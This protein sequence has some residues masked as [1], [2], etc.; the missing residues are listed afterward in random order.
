MMIDDSPLDLEVLQICLEDVGFHRFVVT[1]DSL[2]T[3]GLVRT[4][5]PDV[6]LLDLSMP[7][8]TGFELL[9]AFRS[10]VNLRDI[11]VMIVTSN[12]DAETKLQ[13]LELGAT[14]LLAKPVDPIELG[15]RLKNMLRAKAYRDSL[16]NYSSEL[17]K[18]V[19]QRT[20]QLEDVQRQ[21]IHCLARAAEYRDDDTGQ[22]VFRV[23]RYAAILA[24]EL[25]MDAANVELLEMAAQLHDVGKIGIPDAILLKPGKFEP[26]EF[27]V[28]RQHCDLGVSIIQGDSSYA[29]NNSSERVQLNT[30]PVV[31]MA[32]SIA[33]THHERWDGSGYPRGLKGEMIP[34][35][36]RIV[37]VADVFDALS[38]KRPYKDPMPLDKCV[39]IIR[40]GSGAHFD[41]RVVEAFFA[42]L[43]K[44]LAVRPV[45]EA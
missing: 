6:V 36:G 3:I 7:G 34:L 5:Q 12:T 9:T 17:E 19:R 10:D 13:S 1:S 24:S 43:D 25:G 20:R 30:I 45:A 40:Q 38:S 42:V 32:M 44:L 29:N 22:H 23:G 11:P 8:V 15:L 37:A 18:Q 28:M 2:Q 33:A 27:A 35:E 41:P 26:E 39:A 16:T 31:R 21:I 4:H 14:E